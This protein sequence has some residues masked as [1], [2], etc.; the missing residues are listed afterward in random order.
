MISGDRAYLEIK[1][2]HLKK[3]TLDTIEDKSHFRVINTASYCT[4]F[5]RFKL[6]RVRMSA[7]LPEI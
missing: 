5:D 2:Q 3:K 7:C 6:T 4:S 1:F